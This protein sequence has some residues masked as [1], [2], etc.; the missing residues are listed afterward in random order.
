[1]IGQATLSGWV[2]PNWKEIRD[3][4]V[5]RMDLLLQAPRR[6]MPGIDPYS[7]QTFYAMTPIEWQVWQDIRCV[8]VVFY[9][10]LPVGR[11]F[12]DF[13]NPIARVA[14]ECDGKDFH[15]A[16]KDAARDAELRALGWTVYRM[17]GRDCNQCGC[18]YENEDGEILWHG[19]PAEML[20]REIRVLHEI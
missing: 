6:G 13:G 11:F 17:T 10:Q 16:A 14:I 3:F 7:W 8:G 19:S 5:E 20:L 12:V 4:Y 9:P 15:D 2:P 1:M 18:D